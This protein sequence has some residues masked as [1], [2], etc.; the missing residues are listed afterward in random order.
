[1]NAYKQDGGWRGGGLGSGAEQD[2]GMRTR[3]KPAKV[4]LLCILEHFVGT[5]RYGWRRAVADGGSMHCMDK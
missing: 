5:D 4:N 3:A 1:V 2:R